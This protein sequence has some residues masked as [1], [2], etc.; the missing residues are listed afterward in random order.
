MTGPDE[1]AVRL[2][3]ARLAEADAR[4]R[5]REARRAEMALL[6]DRFRDEADEARRLVVRLEHEQAAA[7][8]AWMAANC[9]E[10]DHA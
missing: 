8:R 3:A 1:I 4:A 2:A 6:G 10:H 5:E 7:V 9:G